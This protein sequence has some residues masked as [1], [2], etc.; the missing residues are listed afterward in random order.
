MTEGSEKQ[1]LHA[2]PSL[3]TLTWPKAPNLITLPSCSFPANARVGIK[4][5]S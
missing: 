1:L 2:P 3:K 5:W 4:F